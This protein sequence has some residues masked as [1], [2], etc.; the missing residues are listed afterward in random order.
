M[1]ARLASRVPSLLLVSLVGLAAAEGGDA[2]RRQRFLAA[3]AASLPPENGPDR[4]LSPY[5]FVDGGDPRVDVFPLHSTRANVRIAGTV[6]DVTVTQVYR[7]RGERTL[8]AIYLFPLSTR[9][10]V[11][12]MKMTVGE[13]VIEAQIRERN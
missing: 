11:H 5:F 8:E 13:R 2:A 6:A 3:A 10:A 4:T 9:A 12:A 7:N 1:H